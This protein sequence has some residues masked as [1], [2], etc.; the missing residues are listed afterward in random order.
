MHTSPFA[1]Q[2][3][4]WTTT[5]LRTHEAADRWTWILIV[6][7]TQPRLTRPLAANLHREQPRIHTRTDLR[8]REAIAA[9]G[10]L[11]G[12]IDA[13]SDCSAHI[14]LPSAV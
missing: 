12:Q 13:G 14:V 5:N 8:Y 3:L 6:A 2:T 1:T 10:R 11:D 4:G 7:P 9:S